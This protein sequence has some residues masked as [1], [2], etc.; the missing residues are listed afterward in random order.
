MKHHQP[1]LKQPSKK[2][3]V[4]LMTACLLASN[5]I[6]PAELDSAN[7][8]QTKD[9]LQSSRISFAG[10][11]KSPTA[12]GGSTVYIYT[13]GASGFRSISTANLHIGDLLTIGTG[14]YT[15]NGIIS[16]SEFSVSPVLA[17]GDVADTTA[18]YLKAKPQHVLTF[19]TA[20]AD[21][22]G[23][24]RVLIPAA[25]ATFND[26][27]PDETG[28]DFGGGTITISGTN[29]TG[30][31]F[32]ST[33]N[34]ATV[35]GGTGC[36]SPANY[37]CFEFHYS[38]NGGIGTAI[39]LSVG[40]TTGANSLIAPAP[41]STHTEATADTYSFIVRQYDSSNNLVDST[42]GKMAVIEAVRVTATVDPTITFSIAGVAAA[43]TTCGTT[44]NID[45]TT[46][47]NAPLAVAFGSLPLNSFVKA[48]HKLQV[49]TNAGYGYA[50]TAI[51]NAALSRNGA[52]NTTIADTA[53]DS[54]PCT[55]T[56]AKEWNTATNNGF[57]YAIDRGTAATVSATYAGYNELTRSFSAKPF[58][59]TA[60]ASPE[61]IMSSS[62]TANAEYSY[63]CYRI[64]VNA[65]QAAGDYENQVTYTATAS[66]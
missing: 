3:S 30:Y 10:R 65:Q 66:F 6:L 24:F 23:Y 32:A 43:T 9:T 54:G 50:V 29:T 31:T 63:V 25:S 20:S 18:I 11:V 61:T 27:N 2:L 58:P 64:S 57:G 40:T 1:R 53:C 16:S 14:S 19:N 55:V 34:A 41:S 7:L 56:S 4:L 46:G 17:G 49:S 21:P 60:S 35:S 47:T 39:T 22:N 48:S 26:G 28:F 62:A 33:V 5:F 51:E 45:T 42:V 8:T 59:A 13:T 15:V 52:G 44:N 38:G 12:A 36:T 37:H